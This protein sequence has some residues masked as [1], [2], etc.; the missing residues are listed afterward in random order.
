MKYLLILLLL[1]GCS[2]GKPPGATIT[3]NKVYLDPKVLIPCQDL[4][5]PNEPIT[6]DSLLA[7]SVANAELYLD[8]RL[9]QEISIKLLKEFAG[10]KESNDTP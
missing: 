7:T 1:A 4:V 5:M 9:K 6:F 3:D 10:H 8:C 2:F